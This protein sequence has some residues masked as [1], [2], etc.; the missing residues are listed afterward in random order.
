[1][2]QSKW[3]S[4][5]LV[6]C[7]CAAGIARGGTSYG[8]EGFSYLAGSSLSSQN[9]GS[10][11]AG[12]WGSAGGLDATIA[13]SSLTFSNLVVSGGA[14]STAGN[15]PP[16]QG[17]SVAYWVRNLGTTLGADNTTA[18]LSFLFRPDAGFGFYGGLGFGNLFVGLSGN[19]SFFGLEGPGG[20]I[21][22]SSVSAVAGKTVLI[23]VRFD[24]LPGND[25]VLLYINPTP[26]QPEPAVPNVLKTDLD[27]G[28]VTSLAINN[29][30]GF[31]T[32]EIR[33]GSSFDA[34]TPPQSVAVP[35]LSTFG[36]TLAAA[37]LAFLAI[38]AM[39]HYL[40]RA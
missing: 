37:A 21:N 4:R 22:L 13:A 25:R 16:G 29:Y 15:Q 18:Y 11:W 19:Q 40:S 24:F 30:G 14:L 34:V 2:R 32:D 1:L 12:A 8:Y 36:L 27:V 20:D 3:I 35:A 28:S 31:T 26:G 7:I 33:I 23:V 9:G 38:R 39:R 10:G 17:S 6:A 5:L